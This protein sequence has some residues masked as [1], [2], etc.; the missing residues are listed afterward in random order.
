EA[1]ETDRARAGFE[2]RRK[3]QMKLARNRAFTVPVLELIGGLAFGV[4]LLIAG[5][6][7]TAHEMTIGDL[8]G[9][10]TAFATATP[11][12]RAIGQFNTLMNEAEAALAGIFGVIDERPGIIDRADAKPLAVREG[13][14][15]FAD[16]SFGYREGETAALRGVS[17]SVAPGET[18]AL[19][20]PS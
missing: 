3:L 1:H 11:A 8:I 15:T 10:T 19:V 14:V 6:R 5:F 17:F 20:G 7:I 2:T 12:A 4:V 16:V 13:R 9:I 18:V